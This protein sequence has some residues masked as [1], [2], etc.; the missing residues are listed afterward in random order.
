MLHR[1]INLNKWGLFVSFTLIT[2]ILS[3]IMR[4]YLPFEQMLFNSLSEQLSVERI[5]ALTATQKKWEWLGYIFIPLMLLIKW[6][7]TTIPFYIGAIFFDLKL[8][9]KKAFHIVLASEIVFLLL[10][11]IKF[12]WFYFHK[13]TLNLEYLQFFMPLSLINLFEMNELDKW[14]VYPLQIVNVFEITYWLLLASLFAKE[15]K[16]PFW[17]AFEFVLATY[18]VGLLIWVIFMSFLILNFS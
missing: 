10:L 11:L 3:W 1:L 12:L 4:N 9:F 14:F 2:V 5:K 13:D 18:G 6:S 15:I 8:T 7:L 16:K 17:K